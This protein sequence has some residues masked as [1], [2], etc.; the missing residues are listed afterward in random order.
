MSLRNTCHDYENLYTEFEHIYIKNK[1]TSTINENNDLIFIENNIHEAILNN[2]PIEDKLNI[3]IC[4][5]N[6]C[7]YKK[8]YELANKFINTMEK[9]KDVNLYVVELIYNNQTFHVTNKDNPKHLQLETS[10]EPLWIKENLLNLGTKLLPKNWKAVAFCDADIEF[11]NPRFAIDVLKILNGSRD[12]IQMHSH[13][14]DLDDNS[15]AMSIFSSFGYQYTMKRPYTRIGSINFYHPGYTIAM[16][17]NAYEKIDGLYQLSILGAGDHNMFLSFVGKGITSLSNDVTDEY[18]ASILDFEHK[19][20]G[21]L[22]GYT[23]GIIRHFFHG[24]KKNRHYSER[25]KILITH[26]YNP[27][28]HITFNS[29]GLMIPSE[30]CPKEL[31]NDIKLY[32]QSR[33][34]DE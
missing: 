2:E 27:Y 7:L 17:R 20:K 25:W 26:K 8:R 12:V 10:T 4:I 14:I 31:L 1:T 30:N 5:S 29:N 13:C 21:L 34:E 23:P 19:C 11:D 6:P 16:T 24:S 32:F 28:T 22:I 33:N 18:K 9:N 15:N 3:I